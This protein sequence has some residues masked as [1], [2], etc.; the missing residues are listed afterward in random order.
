MRILVGAPP[1]GTTDTVARAIAAEMGRHLAR[2]VVVENQPGAGGNIAAATVARAPAD[3]TT[4][5]LAFTSHAINASLYRSLPFDPVASFTPLGLL[6]TSWSMLVAHPSVAATDLRDLVQRMQRAPEAF[7][8][9]VAAIGSS[10][11][12]AGEDFQRRAGVRILDVPYSG[13]APA[14]A[15]VLAGFEP[16]MFAAIGTVLQL[17]QAGKLKAYGVT[18]PRRLPRWPDV[19]AIAEVL[20]GFESMAW[21]GLFA[22]AGLDDL[23]ATRISDAARDAIRNE[24]LQG[25]LDAQAITAVGSSPA[26]FARFLRAEIRRWADL[27]RLS[28]AK[29]E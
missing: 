10:V 26:D 12:L 7:S 15:H 1:G 3:G 22:P 16:L 2:D 4:L 27:I 8:F 11:H 19:P 18:S 29:A 21:F 25:V 17:L 5:L 28:G 24:A 20:P 9:A 14:L 13:T 23:Q 6:A